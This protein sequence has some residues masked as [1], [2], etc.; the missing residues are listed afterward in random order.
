MSDALPVPEGPGVKKGDRILIFRI[1]AI[2]ITSWFE[3]VESLS[4]NPMYRRMS[5]YYFD[6]SVGSCPHGILYGD[7]SRWAKKGADV[8]PHN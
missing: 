7:D 4:L 2:I 1:S 3:E 5:S 8:V 6:A